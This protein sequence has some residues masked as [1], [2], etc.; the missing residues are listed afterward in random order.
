MTPSR[1]FSFA[2]LRTGWSGWR[3]MPGSLAEEI[4]RRNDDAEHHGQPDP[5]GKSVSP[6]AQWPVDF[7][8]RLWQWVQ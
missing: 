1:A 6:A 3:L 7:L 4:E 2:E 5:A 8:V